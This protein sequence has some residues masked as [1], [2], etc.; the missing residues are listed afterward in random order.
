[1]LVKIEVMVGAVIGKQFNSRLLQLIKGD[2]MLVF[3]IYVAYL[4]LWIILIFL[5]SF[6]SWKLLKSKA[7]TIV[8]GFVAFGTMYWHAFGDYI[9]TWWAHKQL[10]EKEAGFKVYV[11][12][13]QWA[14][15]NPGVLDNLMPYKKFTQK[16]GFELGNSRI[17]MRVTVEPLG[18]GSVQ[19]SVVIVADMKTKQILSKNVDFSRG[20]G[21]LQ[22][23]L[24]FWLH[25]YSCYSDGE[26][27][28]KLLMRK[29]FLRKL[30]T[31]WGN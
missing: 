3:L 1:M 8:A 29:A 19:R 22:N 5:A 2:L 24:K 13:E 14:E 30:N 7:V 21:G 12:P 16:D 15:K 20:Y 18:D 25:S 6:I 26:R 4:A 31:I 28:E 17:G 9:P 10:C 27:R 11:T 23:S